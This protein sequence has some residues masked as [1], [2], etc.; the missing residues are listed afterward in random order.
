[1]IQNVNALLSLIKENRPGFPTG[2]F[3]HE[4][5][6]RLLH[7]KDEEERRDAELALT[8]ILSSRNDTFAAEAYCYLNATDR[9]GDWAV[10]SIFSFESDP[11]KREMFDLALL[12]IE[13]RYIA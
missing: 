6:E 7:P 3:I 11:D 12:L 8:D 10:N 5:G 2:V 1:M 13:K 4:I 9:K